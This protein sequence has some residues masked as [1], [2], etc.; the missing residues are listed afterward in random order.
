M[1]TWLSMPPGSTSSPVASMVSRASP[2]SW[3]SAATRPSRI[4]TSQ[5]K[6]SAAVATVPPLMTMS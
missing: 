3:P 6:V 4:A 2:R 1:C 5:A